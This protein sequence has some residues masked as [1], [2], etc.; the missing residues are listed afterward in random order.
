MLLATAR[1]GQHILTELI[2]KG[3]IMMTKDN[4]GIVIQQLIEA[5]RERRPGPETL[6]SYEVQ[7]LENLFAWVAEEQVSVPETVRSIT[8]AS[9][10]A[11]HVSSI[12]RRD[13]DE[14]IQFLLD[15]RLSDIRN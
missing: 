9:F 6:N 2:L 1:I 15:L 4:A 10:D 14:V 13:Y 7:A 12:Q 5:T 3:A 8:E 11:D